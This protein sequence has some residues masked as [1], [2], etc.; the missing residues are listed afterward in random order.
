MTKRAL[1]S[2]I[3]GQDGSYLADYLISLGYEV[4]GIIRRSSTFSTERIDQHVMDLRNPER[5][6][7]LHYGDLLD[8]TSL[9]TIVKKVAPDEIYNLG[10]QSHVKVSFENPAYTT[11]TIVMG[12]LHLLEAMRSL[13]T[14][15]RFYQASSSEMYGSSSPPQNEKTPFRPQSP[16]ACAKVFAHQ[17]CGN[18]R[19]AYG[20]HISCGILFNHEGPRRS[21]QFVT[22]K[23]TRAAA[24][25]YHHVDDRLYLGNLG[26]K[27][28]W[29]F[30]GDYVRA[31]HAMLQQERGDDYVIA[32]GI[33][34]SVRDV[35]DVA[36][37]TLDLDW[38]HYVELDKRYLRPTE[39][40]H[41]LGDPSKAYEKLGWMPTMD[42]VTLIR[43][44]TV[45]DADDVRSEIAGR[46]P[47]R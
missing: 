23:I 16:Y 29:G 43:M 13:E 46:L 3:T 47:R 9:A 39:V 6:L 12:T 14:P 28:D 41:L 5:R 44:M 34:F 7:H 2:G 15:C 33:S 21:P 42:F 25:I 40:D 36:F 17:L 24:R 30:A 35:L 38:R 27:R 37:G 10:A 19:E 26:A 1:V 20:L 11:E 4:H 32:T 18:Y 8:G 45:A 22:R 31:M